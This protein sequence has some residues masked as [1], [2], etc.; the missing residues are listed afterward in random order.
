MKSVD[1]ITISRKNISL[2]C[3]RAALA[4]STQKG[5]A[6]SRM[7]IFPNAGATF[8]HDRQLAPTPEERF[9]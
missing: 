6:R 3:Y 8:N 2:F 1:L 9:G 4:V 5:P 7:T